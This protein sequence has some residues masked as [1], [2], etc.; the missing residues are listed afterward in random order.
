MSSFMTSSPGITASGEMAGGGLLVMT[1]KASWGDTNDA[2]SWASP[3][4]TTVA[5]TIYFIGVIHTTSPTTG[6]AALSNISGACMANSTRV[7]NEGF[8]TRGVPT[9]QTELWV[10]TGNGG[11]GAL[12]VDFPTTRTAC[13]VHMC[14]ATAHLNTTTSP[15]L[16]GVRYGVVQNSAT[17]A[18]TA[19]GT[20]AAGGYQGSLAAFANTVNGG[21]MLCGTNSADTWGT[22]AVKSGWNVLHQAA[23]LTPNLG[24]MMAWCDHPDTTVAAYSNVTSG[25]YDMVMCELA[26]S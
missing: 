4:Q 8:A 10:M 1:P 6:T 5:G 11:T 14:T 7:R 19:N 24:F 21:L 18:D 22:P 17:G 23:V 12:T 3:S 20:A 26:V 2:T 15:I 9:Y 13:H 25:A 16:D